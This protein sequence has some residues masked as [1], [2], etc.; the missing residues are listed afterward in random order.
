MILTTLMFLLSVHHKTPTTTGYFTY[1]P[2]S[3]SG[4]TG[5]GSGDSTAYVADPNSAAN[6]PSLTLSSNNSSQN[7][8]LGGTYSYS[9]VW[10]RLT[11]SDTPPSSV[12]VTIEKQ[13][14]LA[15]FGTGVATISQ[16][17][18]QLAEMDDTNDYVTGGITFIAELSYNLPMVLQS[19]GTYLASGTLTTDTLSSTW[20]TGSGG[21]TSTQENFTF[22]SIAGSN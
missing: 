18:T 1:V 20:N 19:N 4:F 10:T 2:G 12:T 16:G 5:T 8:T 15:A 11:S 17:T 9:I 14:S 13:C 6:S 22:G 7:Y 21:N 3:W